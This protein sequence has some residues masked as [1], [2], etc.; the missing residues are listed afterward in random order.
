M[1]KKVSYDN[2]YTNSYLYHNHRIDIEIMAMVFSH[3][4]CRWYLKWCPQD[5][6]SD[7]FSE[8]SHIGESFI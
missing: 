6:V 7:G 1:S 8:I 2:I 3:L 4:R 5:D